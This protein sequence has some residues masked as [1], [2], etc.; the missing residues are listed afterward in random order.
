MQLHVILSSLTLTSLVYAAPKAHFSKRTY[1]KFENWGTDA[2]SKDHKKKLTDALPDAIDL[3]TR[4]SEDYNTYKDIWSKYFPESDHDDVKKVYAQIVSDPTKPDKGESRLENCQIVGED[5]QKGQPQ[6]S[7]AEGAEAWT[8]NL[9]DGSFGNPPGTSITYFCDPAYTGPLKYQDMRCVNIGNTLSDKLD[10]LGATILHEW[11]HNDAI[12][13]EAI[14]THI[15][16][17]GG[18]KGY[19]PW[20]TRQMLQNDPSSCKLNADSYTWLALEVFWTKLCL[21][22]KRFSDPVKPATISCFHAGDPS[23]HMGVCP[24]LGST[25][26]CDC[27]SAGKYPVLD[28]DDICG[29]TEQ[30]DVEAMDIYSTDCGPTEAGPS[31]PECHNYTAP[32]ADVQNINSQLN[33]WGDSTICCSSG[34]G[35]CV[36]I[37]TSGDIAVDLCSSETTPLCVGCARLGNYV[38]GMIGQCQK[39]GKVGGKQDIVEA[40]GLNVQI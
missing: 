30:P 9:P 14:G 39:D 18:E 1:P 19:G 7:C 31:S 35:G 2:V 3:V 16:D 21:N 15:A 12:G 25:G 4:V 23:G 22:G 33:S 11:T 10:F 26:W 28:G 32:V 17:I 40:P 29:Y 20:G 34:N 13:K 37:A 8:S 38:A 5:F 27:G 36:N 6:D 24:N